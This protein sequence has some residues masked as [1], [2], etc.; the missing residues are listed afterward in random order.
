MFFLHH[1]LSDAN[2]W[3]QNNKIS[4]EELVA[5]ALQANL[6]F[7]WVNA[8]RAVHAQ[9]ARAQARSEDAGRGDA[10]RRG[11][12]DGIPVAIKDN[13]DEKGVICA[14][15]SA[16]YRDRVPSEDAEVVLRLRRAGALILGRTN[17]HELADGVTSENPHFGPVHNPWRMGYHPGGSSGGSAAAVA[18][19]VVPVALGTDTGGSVRIPAALCGVVGLKPSLGLIPTGGVVPLSPTLDH[20]GVLARTVRDTA[21]AFAALSGLALV[22]DWE[23]VARARSRRK[24]GVLSGFAQA[25]DEPVEGLF[26]HAL[27][28]LADLGFAP[29]P[30]AQEALAGAPKIL[31]AIYAPEA[32]KVHAQALRERAEDF[33]PEVRADLARGLRLSPETI[34]KAHAER[35]RLGAGLQDALADLDFLVSPTTP[36][37]ARPLGSPDPHTYLTYTCPFNLSGHPAISVPM[38]W[39]DGLPVGLQIVAGHGQETALLSIALAFEQAL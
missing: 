16:A 39:V 9:E 11:P 32:A 31:S 27:A 28:K 20:L 24:I 19:G 35:Q 33:S 17:M 14:A 3:L 1:T 15:G 38:G 23:N 21:L 12:L 5:F 25:A 26:Q 37:P 8:F 7:E 29:V 34:Q 10:P 30:V 36:H 13:I 18:A 22:P 2:T 4:S 6:A